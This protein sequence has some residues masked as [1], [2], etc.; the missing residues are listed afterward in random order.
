[1]QEY[2]YEFAEFFYYTPGP[3][4][5]ESGIW[6]IRAGRT[7]AK[8]NYKVGPKRIECYSIHFIQEGKLRLQFDHEQIELQRG[9]IFCLFPERTYCYERIPSEQSLRMSWLAIGGDRARPLLGL[10]GLTEERPYRRTANTPQV[11]LS[12]ERAVN[13]LG[14]AGQWTAAAAIELQSLIWGLFADLTKA[15]T[16]TRESGQ[17]DWVRACMSYIELHATEGISVQQV[18]DFAGVHRSYLSQTFASQTGLSPMKYLQKV[19]MEKARRLLGESD[20]TMTEVALSLGYPNLYAFTRAYRTYHK[21]P[22][23]AGRAARD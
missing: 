6:P 18:A 21:E 14:A 20:A 8:P 4:D 11:G 16:S 5:M 10:A 19:R 2:E 12:A 22:P 17:A 1:M 15:A 9:D 7:K 3:F 13:A 23:A